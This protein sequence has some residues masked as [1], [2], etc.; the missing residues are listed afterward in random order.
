MHNLFSLVIPFV[1][2]N[3]GLSSIVLK[4]ISAAKSG[5]RYWCKTSKK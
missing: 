1:L 4:I 2:L 5:L 3:H